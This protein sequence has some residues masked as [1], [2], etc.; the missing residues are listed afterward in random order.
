MIPVSKTKQ[1]QTILK[2]DMKKNSIQSIYETARTGG[3]VSNQDLT[4]L[5]RQALKRNF[6]KVKF[7]VRNSHYSSIDVRW[8]DGPTRS[9][10][11][12][13]I[14]CFETKSFDGM[15][16]LAYY[17]GFW[18]YADG[19]SSHA[20]CE[21]TE[22]SR[23]VVS[24]SVGSALRPDGVLVTNVAGC[25]VFENRELSRE[26]LRTVIDGLRQTWGSNLNGVS[27]DEKG[28]LKTADHNQYQLIHRTA[29]EISV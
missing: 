3:W 6:P 26:F 21:G 5:V 15:I 4:Y 19:S 9:D 22:G 18:L 25:Y 8:T 29:S 7:S 13:V 28:H 2:K 11:Q 24:E 16:D 20:V 17:K 12:R 27:F 23:G 1:N 14:G 10:V